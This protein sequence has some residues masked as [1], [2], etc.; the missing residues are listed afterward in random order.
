MKYSPET[1]EMIIS[2][3][4]NNNE[5]VDQIAQDTGNHRSTLYAWLKQ[6]HELEREKQGDTA[7]VLTKRH[8][9]EL[10]SKVKRLEG[11]IEILKT[12][13]CTVHAPLHQRLNAIEELQDRYNVHM[14]C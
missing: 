5:S 11:I 3:H 2:R 14:L 12:V 13:P 8:Y 10:E 4:L 1:K 9:R 7:L 6:Y